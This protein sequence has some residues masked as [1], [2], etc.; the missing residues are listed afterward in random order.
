[1]NTYIPKLAA[2]CLVFLLSGCIDTVD[3]QIV[4][5]NNETN[6]T[7]NTTTPE[8]KKP[9]TKKPE[10]KKPEVKKPE[11]KK[12][13]TK[14]PETKKPI[15][16]PP[17]KKP[18]TKKPE[19]K[20]PET[21]KPETKKPETKKPE[22]KKPEAV[23]TKTKYHRLAWDDDPSTTAVVG[24]CAT[25]DGIDFTLKYGYTTDENSWNSVD[26]VETHTFDRLKS[27]FVHLS[28][29]TPESAVYYKICD[30]S[31]CSQRYWF[32]TASDT[33]TKPY[34]FI[35]GGDT[36]SGLNTRRKANKLIAK[37]RPLFIMHGGDYTNS[38]NKREMQTLLGDFEMMYSDDTIDNKEYKRIYPLVTAMGN[39][40][41]GNFKTL[42]EVFG[43]DYNH[44]GVCDRYDDT[45]TAF[46]VTPLL[47]VY[48]LNSEFRR[49]DS[50]KQKEQNKWFANDIKS[51]A[52]TSSSWRVVQYH[53]PMFPHYTGKH[54][55]LEIFNWWADEFYNHSVNL[56]V[57]SDTHMC[58]V[59]KVVK[60]AS[61]G[62][63]NYEEAVKGGTVYVGEGSWGA[64]SRSANDSKSW[65]QDL[66]S[67][68][69]FKVITVY[70]DKMEVRTAQF[71][72]NVSTLSKDDRQNN[73]TLLPS[74]IS[75]WYA[76]GIGKVMTLVK[77][78]SKQS[79]LDTSH[80]VQPQNSV[81]TQTNYE[82]K[83]KQYDS[84]DIKEASIDILGDSFISN[85]Q[86]N[87]T[88]NI[89]D[90]E[91]LVSLD[92][93]EF[94]ES[95]SLIK[96]DLSKLPK[97]AL[98]V[99]ATLDMKS[100]QNSGGEYVL[101]TGAN[102]WDEGSVTWDNIGAKMQLETF[103]AKFKVKD[104][105]IVIDI[106]KNGIDTLNSW[107]HGNTNTG[108]AISSL[109]GKDLHIHNKESMLGAS[110]NIRYV[111]QK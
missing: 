43:V 80:N 70:K 36:R 17:T 54:D 91:L 42:C 49:L 87:S 109:D 71:N 33:S 47:R 1:M 62:T 92:N 34:V 44:N 11:T 99:G 63:R 65:T 12:P 29:L 67:I 100:T 18:E 79:V 53:K 77:N 14:K 98:I 39:H 78:N 8:V 64:D 111:L 82:T 86:K 89:G 37:I 96:F 4:S 84:K 107:L 110:L 58:K 2:L 41:D 25:T 15:I 28:G 102:S 60:P 73:S 19:T 24:F 20:K 16:T 68:N 85:I 59:T 97:N 88:H 74:G 94:G 57:E 30:S 38:N 55:N 21:K 22:T 52:A 104:T 103:V 108:F 23:S 7:T 50:T 90:E 13:E 105:N 93:K 3:T 31:G 5:D 69:Q 106:N 76:D 75:W 72:G 10:T 9:E 51:N 66:A 101:Y 83:T 26:V 61:N 81:K 56:V 40:E 6:E 95:I 27:Y 32:K 46:N 48:T 45:Y 35:A